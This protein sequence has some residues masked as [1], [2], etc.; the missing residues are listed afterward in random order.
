MGETTGAGERGRAGSPGWAGRTRIAGRASTAGRACRP[1]RRSLPGPAGGFGKMWHK[2]Y[3]VNLGGQVSPRAAIAA[4][5]AEVPGLY[6]AGDRLAVPLGGL[7]PADAALLAV[8]TGGVTLSTGVPVLYA[9]DESCTLASPPG[10]LQAA[11]LTVSAERPAERTILRAQ[12]LMRAGDPLGELYLACGGHAREDRCWTAALT[13]LA[14]RLGAAGAAVEV[15][16]ICLD[17]RRQ[18]HRARNLWRGATV[19]GVLHAA[20][21]PLAAGRRARPPLGTDSHH[22]GQMFQREKAG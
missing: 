8:T 14:S 15:H 19:R 3:R 20:A 5:K 1:A 6:P 9:D 16:G 21:A 13:A 2:A 18:W 17:S 4:W 10:H 12:L 11:W 22:P 7:T